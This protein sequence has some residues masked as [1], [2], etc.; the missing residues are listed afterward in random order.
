MLAIFFMYLVTLFYFIIMFQIL[1]LNTVHRVS[2]R[3]VALT[4]NAWKEMVPVHV[5]VLKILLVTPM[6]AVGQ[7][8]LLTRIVAQH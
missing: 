7:N 5:N 4:Q 8:V 6:K 2:L 3:H 1:L